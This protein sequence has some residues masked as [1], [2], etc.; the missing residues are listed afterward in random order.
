MHAHVRDRLYFLRIGSKS[1]A[2]ENMA[3][4]CDL[5]LGET[6][7]LLIQTY[8]ILLE[9]GEDT[10]EILIVFCHSRFEH[11]YVVKDVLASR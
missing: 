7:L 11:D 3:I 9:S 4:E 2:A 8:V 5:T 10:I 1:F 6:T